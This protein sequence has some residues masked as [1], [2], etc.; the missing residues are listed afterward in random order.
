MTH[1]KKCSSDYNC[2]SVQSLGNRS[3]PGSIHSGEDATNDHDRSRCEAERQHEKDQLGFGHGL[4]LSLAGCLLGFQGRR[5][6]YLAQRAFE[7]RLAVGGTYL[8]RSV[9]ELLALGARVFSW[10]RFGHPS[11]LPDLLAHGEVRHG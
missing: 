4:C 6:R 8:A 3:R 5:L 11:T 9:N 7:Y 2:S 10:L 1:P